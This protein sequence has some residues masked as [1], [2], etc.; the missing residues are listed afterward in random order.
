M[1]YE[2]HAAAVGGQPEA[3]RGQ[4]LLSGRD[5]APLLLLLLLLLLLPPIMIINTLII[6]I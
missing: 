4:P 3:R 2:R 5:L 6:T 1:A